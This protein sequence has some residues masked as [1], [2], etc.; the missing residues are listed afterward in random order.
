VTPFRDDG[1]LD[2]AAFEAN[3]D[4][5]A[6]AGFA[7]VLVLGSN[8]EAVSLE[9]PE[10]LALVRAARRWDGTLLVG[11]GL[12]TTRATL[13]L[14][15]KV[16]DLGAE[17]A[18][19]LTPHYY[20]SQMGLEALRRHYETVADG[21]P[22]PVL[23]YS[24][25]AVTGIA[26]SPDLVA[27][28]ADHPRIRGLKDSSGDLGGM[29]RLL[30]AAGGRLEV[31]CG[32]APVLY[33]ALCLGASGGLLAVAGC[34]PRATTAVFA[35]WERGDHAEARRLQ[36]LLSPLAR[37]VTTLH[38]VPGL[39]AAVDAAGYRGGHVRAPLLPAP[40]SVREEVTRLVEALSRDLAAA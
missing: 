20:R 40:A 37:A 28:L 7:G 29:G 6:G 36:R 25:P 3:L 22:I 1:A 33:P 17:A 35:A 9:E 12:A 23:L 16:A 14:T 8:G 24:M 5:Y 13:E 18:L 38:G 27:A 39:K 4:A 11:T 2:L 31:A 32:S 34:A 30:E 19:V 10:K 26:V 21:S 15:R